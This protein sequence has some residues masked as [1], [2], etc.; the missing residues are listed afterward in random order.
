MSSD[1]RKEQISMNSNLKWFIE[2]IFIPVLLA[3]IAGYF[4]LVASKILPNPF[5]KSARPQTSNA[6]LGALQGIWTGSIANPATSQTDA[7]TI[8]FGDCALEKV[9]GILQIDRSGSDPCTGN[10]VFNSIDGDRLL[11]IMQN[12]APECGPGR[13]EYLELL[14]QNTMLFVSSGSDGEIRVTLHRSQ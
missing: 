3:L 8:N 12:R 2:R 9:C 1:Q 14:D 13:S 11:F 5:S 10:I 4:T 6:D 7:I